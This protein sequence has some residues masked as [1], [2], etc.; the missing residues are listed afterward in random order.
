MFAAC[1][2]TRIGEVSGCR[3]GDIDTDSWVWTLRRQTT[4]GP[5]GLMDKGT[6]GR[7]HRSIPIIAEIRPLILRR[8]ND[9]RTRVER[10]HRGATDDELRTAFLGARVFVGPRGGRIAT[11]VLRDATQW[12]EV[13]TALGFEHLR[14]HDLRHTG[15]TWFAD[16]GVPLH[17]L[18]RIAGHVDP[19]I[20]QRYLHP[21]MEAL[22]EDGERLSQ[23]LRGRTGPK[24]GPKPQGRPLNRKPLLRWSGGVFVCRG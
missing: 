6:K 15:L 14:R 3:V 21:D 23:H 5:G 4:P 19:R 9:A 7:R 13:V 1:T 16:S 10:E 22:R 2:A 24:I 17:R 11:G 12:D 20:T 8:I 18:Q